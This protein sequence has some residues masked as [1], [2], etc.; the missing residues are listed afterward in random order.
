MG[1]VILQAIALVSIAFS[2]TRLTVLASAVF[3]G[4]SVG[5]LLMLQPLIMAEAF[6][7]AQISRIYAFNQLFSTIGVAGG[8]VVLGLVR[9]Q[10]SYETSFVIAAAASL[11]GFAAF[12][13]A[14]GVQRAQAIWN[15]T[16]T[17]EPDPA[18]TLISDPVPASV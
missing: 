9:D 11:F 14:G 12:W 3:L 8:P 17:V 18:P 2:T 10:T 15:T 7:A 4:I 6:G 16:P 13:L 1:L 5:N